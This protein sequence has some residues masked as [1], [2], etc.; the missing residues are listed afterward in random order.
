MKTTQHLLNILA[1]AILPLSAEEVSPPDFSKVEKQ[2]QSEIQS[3]AGKTTPQ[4]LQK[5]QAL[6]NTLNSIIAIKI[7]V[8]S[9][10]F[11]K[12]DQS[13][14]RTAR[15]Y[16]P[17]EAVA[18]LTRLQI[19]LEDYSKAVK[20][21]QE[22][23]KHQQI[24][25]LVKKAQTIIEK[26]SHIGELEAMLVEIT[27]TDIKQSY[28]NSAISQR[29]QEKRKGLVFTVRCWVRYYDF[30]EAGNPTQANSQ[31]QQIAKS[32]T[33][34]IISKQTIDQAYLPIPPN[35]NS[36]DF[37]STVMKGIANLE[38]IP[39]AIEKIKNLETAAQKKQLNR[40][41]ARQL[42]ETT[43]QPYRGLGKHQQWRWRFRPLHSAQKLLEI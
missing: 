42:K 24:D 5:H 39:K 40:I 4:E 29:Y 18:E 41:Q 38:D 8:E 7:R 34:P 6:E 43:H 15:S 28:N 1:I 33:F 19:A 35:P 21:S 25:D 30:K 26:G 10:R 36:N 23:K 13:F 37:I 11:E 14:P 12:I 3:L 27:A 22:T 9:N 2:F 20:K 32:N 16:I 31:L 17:T